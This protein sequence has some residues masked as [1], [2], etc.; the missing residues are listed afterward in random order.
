MI[1]NLFLS[2]PVQWSSR[3]DFSNV[4][5]EREVSEWTSFHG[6][7]GAVCNLS[8]L[9]QGRRYFFRACAGNI[10]GWG[11]YKLSTPNCVVPSSEC[12]LEANLHLGVFH[13]YFS[14]SSTQAGA[15]WKAAKIG[16]PASSAIWTTCSMPFGWHGRRT[17]PKSPWMPRR[18]PN[19]PSRRKPPSNSSFRRRQSSKKISNGS[20]YTA[21]IQP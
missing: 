8:E 14:I 3:S 10:K 20:Y 1:I 18:R 7:M 17:L 9:I 13:N 21:I 16:S 5:G 19:E 15:M 6:C 11:P 2:I 4:V 12:C